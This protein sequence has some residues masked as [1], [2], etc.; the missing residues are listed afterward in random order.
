M[1]LADFLCNILD[2]DPDPDFMFNSSLKKKY[3]D[4]GSV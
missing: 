4:Q 2:P 3:T 1:I